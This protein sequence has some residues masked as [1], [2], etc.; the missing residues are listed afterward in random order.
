MY[1]N[2]NYNPLIN[3]AFESNSIYEDLK[4]H[5]II[6]LSP[7]GTSIFG[8]PFSLKPEI[9]KY[10]DKLSKQKDLFK[11]YNITDKEIE[12]IKNYENQYEEQ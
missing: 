2:P 3:P 1:L 7:L 6:N 12:E 8:I 5:N 10:L 9:I 4:T 11:Y